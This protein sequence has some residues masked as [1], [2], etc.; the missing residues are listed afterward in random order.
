MTALPRL[1]DLDDDALRTLYA[2]P[3]DP[4]LR[5]NFVSTVDG[6]AQGPDGLSGSINNPADHR[7]FA[8][9]R[10]LADVVVVGAGTVRAEEYRPGPQPL[11]V[12][13]R[14]GALPPSLRVGDLSRVYVATGAAA[15]AL[16]ETRDLLGE[17]A[18]ALGEQEPSLPALVERLHG[19]GHTQVL[20]EGGPGLARDLLGLGLVDELC[21]TTVPRLVGGE[22][23]RILDGGDVDVP[24]RL[25]SLLESDGTLLA[26]WLTR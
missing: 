21:L 22:H 15:P 7:V 26:R 3:R 10:S 5:L 6:A 25:E 1:D 13:T 4:W 14:S 16:S 23:V 8:L 20:C 24:L 19:L 17:R 11:V 12:V 9:L 18:L 2:A